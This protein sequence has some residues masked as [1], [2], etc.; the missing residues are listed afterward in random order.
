MIGGGRSSQGASQGEDERGY[1]YSIAI[2]IA[3][4]KFA[5]KCSQCSR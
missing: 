5:K 2:S 1:V 4:T 3:V